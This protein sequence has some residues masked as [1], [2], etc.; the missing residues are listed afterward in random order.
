MSN[1]GDGRKKI[2]GEDTHNGL[3]VNYVSAL[4]KINV[5][6]CKNDYVNEFSDVLNVTKLNFD[7]F[8]FD[9]LS[10]I[11][12]LQAYYSKEK[13]KCQPDFVYWRAFINIFSDRERFFELAID[14][15]IN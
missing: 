6:I 10:K 1:Q 2:E 12:Y 4:N 3:G 7:F 11:L 13:S 8:H 15:L 14:F 9:F 5:V